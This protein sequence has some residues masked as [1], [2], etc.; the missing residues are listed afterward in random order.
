MIKNGGL[1]L[2][3]TRLTLM[4]QFEKRVKSRFQGTKICLFRPE[5]ADVYLK[6]IGKRIDTV[7][8]FK[9]LDDIKYE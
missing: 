8:N 7:T 5:K 3:T 2:L 6:I 9:I 1:F 4:D